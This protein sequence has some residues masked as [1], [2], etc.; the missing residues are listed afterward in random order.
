MGLYELQTFRIIELTNNK[1]FVSSFFKIIVNMKKYEN[2]ADLHQVKLL[3]YLSIKR[4]RM[5]TKF[6]WNLR[7]RGLYI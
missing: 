2:G 1:I 7:C 4:W 6:V 3:M 5:N